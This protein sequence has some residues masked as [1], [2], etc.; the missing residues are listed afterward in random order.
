MPWFLPICH[1]FSHLFTSN[2]LHWYNAGFIYEYVEKQTKKNTLY[3][4]VYFF[5][6]YLY[7]EPTC[8][9]KVA[10][11]SGTN[12]IPDAHITA[13]SEYDSVKSSAYYARINNTA[14]WGGWLCSYNEM[15]APEPRMYLQVCPLVSILVMPSSH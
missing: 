14:G 10:L 3:I 15:T 11:V 4:K 6:V 7:K 1:S 5:L 13:S 8:G 9:V 12:P 2:V